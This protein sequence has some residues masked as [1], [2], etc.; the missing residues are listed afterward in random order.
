MKRARAQAVR[1]RCHVAVVVMLH[2]HVPLEAA[3]ESVACDRLLAVLTVPCCNWGPSH[4]QCWGRPP[5]ACWVDPGM[6]SEK[7]ELRLWL[8]GPRGA[9]AGGGWRDGAE[10]AGPD[11]RTGDDGS[12]EQAAARHALL[13]ASQ[14]ALEVGRQGWRAPH[15]PPAPAR[16]RH[17]PLNRM[18]P[19]S[20]RP[21]SAASTTRWRRTNRCCRLRPPRCWASGRRHEKWRRPP[22]VPAR[23]RR[24]AKN[25]I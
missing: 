21:R 3:T 1:V 10:G 24:C 5:D 9:D 18:V 4:A 15:A 20:P 23:R 22:S 17:A 8:D 6:L 25:S 12:Q 2:A 14:A 16:R 7:Q 11:H 13:V 19:R